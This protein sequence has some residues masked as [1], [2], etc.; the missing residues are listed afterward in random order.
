MT[1]RTASSSDGFLAKVFR[2]FPQRKANARR[3]VHSPRDHL[4]ITLSLAIDVTLG[5]SGLWLGSWTRVGGT[6]TAFLAPAHGS[7]DNR[8][9]LSQ[10][11][12]GNV[13]LNQ[14]LTF[15]VKIVILF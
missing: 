7:V 9:L 4:I 6:V 3:S 14:N 10:V 13:M 2:D 12:I 8:L 1:G 11:A 5:P 15:R